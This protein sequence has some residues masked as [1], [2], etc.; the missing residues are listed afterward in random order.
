MAGV[1]IEELIKQ[2]EA[3]NGKMHN[4]RDWKL[5]IISSL[6]SDLFEWQSTSLMMLQSQYPNHPQTIAFKKLID[7]DKQQAL[8]ATYQTQMGILKAFF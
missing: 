7:E 8:Y 6:W 1:N 5:H 3:F 2:G 4:G